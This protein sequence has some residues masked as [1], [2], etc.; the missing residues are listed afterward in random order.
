MAKRNGNPDLDDF[1]TYDMACELADRMEMTR[2]EADKFVNN[3][4]SRAGFVPVQTRDSWQRDS[5]NGGRRG[6]STGKRDDGGFND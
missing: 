2:Q 4:M 1:E 5:D 6:R 3:V